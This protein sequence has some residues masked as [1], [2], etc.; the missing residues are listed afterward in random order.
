MAKK[1]PI[2]ELEQPA[3]KP[4]VPAELPTSGGSYTR[5]ADG[6]LVPDTVEQ[7]E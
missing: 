6:N 3:E 7:P 5:D 2:T 4:Q 1:P